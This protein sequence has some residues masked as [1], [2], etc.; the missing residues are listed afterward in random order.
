ME[1][2]TQEL[3][4]FAANLSYQDI[5]AHVVHQAERLILDTCGCAVA[6]YILDNA[7]TFLH[8][9]E[10]LGGNPEA[11]LFP[12]GHKTSV[13][14]AA[15][16]NTSLSNALDLDDNL[17]YHCHF[18]NTTVLPAVAMAERQGC[19]GR[20]LVTAVVA[21]YEVTSRITL[22]QPGVCKIVSPPPNLKIE[23]PP[24]ATHNYNVFSTAVGAGRLLGLDATRM[25]C[26]MG[27]AGLNA[28]VPRTAGHGGPGGAPTM[29]GT[30]Y[31][32]QGWTGVIAALLAEQGVTGP[33]TVL[34]G[35]SGFWRMSGAESCNSAMLTKDL[36]SK[37]WILD[38]SFKAY[39]AGTWMRPAMEAT[40]KVVR[41]HDIRP[42]EIE[43]IVIKNGRL[44]GGYIRNPWAEDGPV[45]EVVGQTNFLYLVVMRAL[46]VPPARWHTKETYTNPVVLDLLKKI[47]FVRDPSH[48]LALYQELMQQEKTQG[49]R[50]ATKSP[51]TVEVHARGTVFSAYAEYA[52]GD[53]FSEET[54]M[55]DEDLAAKFRTHTVGIVRS[56]RAERAIQALLSVSKVADVRTVTPLLTA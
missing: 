12:S 44:V 27:M 22:S 28:P 9:M 39:P 4:E 7:K 35:E 25:A 31:G 46:R 48:E 11:T 34:D 1:S 32:W 36:G 2:P 19:S 17:L 10:A 26:A 38:T 33:T 45:N 55:R 50:R 5:P 54:R 14:T 20:D 41:T 23:Q 3:A 29:K 52:R 13:A 16:V 43:R 18:A 30:N 47:E 56:S 24:L 40:D 37:W 21:A 53:P 15:F 51:T 8:V 42:D 49:V 6:G